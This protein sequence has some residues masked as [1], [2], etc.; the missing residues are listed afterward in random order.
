L[1]LPGQYG[2]KRKLWLSP[3]HRILLEDGR[4]LAARDIPNARQ[5]KGRGN[6][7]YY[8]IVLPNYQT[9]HLVLDGVIAESLRTVTWRQ[10]RYADFL[11][12]PDY[13]RLLK[14]AQRRGDMVIL[15]AG[16]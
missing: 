14:V 4:W 9:D 10:I 8:H 12:H 6:I 13:R 16:K 2:A 15:P 3:E 1:I 7:E 11:K 5:A